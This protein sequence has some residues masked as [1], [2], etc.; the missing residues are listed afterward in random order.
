MEIKFHWFDDDPVPVPLIDD[1]SLHYELSSFLVA[2]YYHPTMIRPNV[3]GLSGGTLRQVAYDIKVFLE[4]LDHNNISIADADFNDDIKPIIEAQLKGSRPEVFNTRI[5]RVRD[6]YDFLKRQGIRTKAFFQDKIVQNRHVNPDSDM[7]SHTRRSNTTKYLKDPSHKKTVAQNDYCGQVISM[8]VFGE[9]YR[10]LKEIDPVYATMAH[11]M[12][13]TFLRVSDVCEMPLHTNTYNKYI[14]VWP[15][16]KISGE[17]FIKYLLLTKGSKDITI[18]IYS[19]TI[20]FLYD[21][22]LKPYHKIRKKL[23]EDKYS[24]RKNAS[25]E[26]GNKRDINRRRIPDDLL[27]INKH[28]TPVKPNMV[29]EAF[30]QIG[31]GI[32]PHMLRHTGVTHTLWNYCEIHDIK[33]EERLAS[34]FAEVLSKQLGHATIETT[35]MYTRTIMRRKAD[36]YMPFS[37]P[38]NHKELTKNMK[39]D[40]VDNLNSFFKASAK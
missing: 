12:M 25:L 22:Y 3:K 30:R 29:E 1:G 39:S 13:Q 11:V 10:R 17:D 27:W 8:D 31:M 7:L 5:S 37:L 9:L 19:P 6:F 18:N 35:M 36:A 4:A 40:I 2:R 34:L 14:D 21:D 26:F 23:F 15:Q 33:P 38:G 32:H 16:H 24:K 20:E 28:G